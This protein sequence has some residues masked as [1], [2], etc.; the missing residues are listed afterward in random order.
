VFDDFYFLGLSVQSVFAVVASASVDQLV[1]FRLSLSI[2]LRSIDGFAI[3][4]ARRKNEQ[5]LTSIPFGL[6]FILSLRIE[7][8]LQN[9]REMR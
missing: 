7:S 3:A 4:L 2:E 5:T 9:K 1:W 6:N 8:V